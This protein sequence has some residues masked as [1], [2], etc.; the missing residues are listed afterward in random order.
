MNVW[1]TF[2]RK[3]PSWSTHIWQPSEYSP[4]LIC[5]LCV[6]RR[7]RKR[8]DRHIEPREVRELSLVIIPSH[9]RHIWQTWWTR[10]DTYRENYSDCSMYVH[11]WSLEIWEFWASS[12][13]AFQDLNSIFKFRMFF[14]TPWAIWQF[15]KYKK[16][17]KIIKFCSTFDK[18]MTNVMRL[19][20]V[21]WLTLCIWL[22]HSMCEVECNNRLTFSIFSKKKN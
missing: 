5:I 1:L 17:M 19:L 18:I 2:C 3:P 15:K 21:I 8:P 20:W 12:L 4:S 9:R 11:T 7:S 22:T 6:K 16:R 14:F 10:K 13:A